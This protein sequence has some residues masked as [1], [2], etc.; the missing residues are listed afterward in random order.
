MQELAFGC[1]QLAFVMRWH[2]LIELPA[3]GN[4]LIGRHGELRPQVLTEK[5]CACACHATCMCV[6]A[7]VWKFLLVST[8][9]QEWW[10]RHTETSVLCL[11][12]TGTDA[13]LFLTLLEEPALFLFT[14]TC[15]PGCFSLSRPKWQLRWL[16]VASQL[17]WA[18]CHQA[19]A[20]CLQKIHFVNWDEWKVHHLYM[21]TSLRKN[22]M[23]D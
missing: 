3:K 1:S 23:W 22:N 17:V 13:W 10:S 9:L 5:W 21:W 16:S 7:K 8:L 12:Q 11:L 19:G 15:Q 6:K 4:I 14:P 20:K 18:K 2:V